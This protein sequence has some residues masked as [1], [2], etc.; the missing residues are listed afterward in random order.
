MQI[1]KYV[2]HWIMSLGMLSKIVF[3]C[4]IA[5]T[6]ATVSTGF[7]VYY[8]SARVI[9]R[10]IYAHTS[11][12]MEQSVNYLN[13]RLKGILVQVHLLQLS[14]NFNETLRMLRWEQDIDYSVGLSRIEPFLSQITA[15]ERILHSIYVYTPKAVFYNLGAPPFDQVFPVVL[16]ELMGTSRPSFIHWGFQ[17]PYVSPLPIISIALQ[18]MTLG[19]TEPRDLYI[20]INLKQEYLQDY[21]NGIIGEAQGEVY[22][23]DEQHR[24][25]VGAN[26]G[27]LSS[28]LDDQDF[29]TKL[30]DAG[31]GGYFK[32][33][34]TDNLLVNTHEFPINGWKMVSIQHESVIFNDLDAIKGM[35]LLIAIILIVLVS[36]LSGLVAQTITKPLHRLQIMMNETLYTNFRARFSP[37]YDDEIGQL[38]HSFDMMSAQVEKLLSQVELEQSLVKQEQ[39][40]KRKAELRALQAQINPHFLYNA[41]DSIYWRAMIQGDSS[42]SEIAVSLSNVFRLG[43]NKGKESTTIGRELEHVTNYMRTQEIVYSGKFQFIVNAEPEL[44]Q[45]E[46]VKIILQPLAENS[47]IHGFQQMEDGGRIS[48]NCYKKENWVCIEVMDNGCGFDKDYLNKMADPTA[49]LEGYALQNIIERLKLYYGETHDFK[50]ESEPYQETKVTIHVPLRST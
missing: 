9:E 3:L 34:Y 47:I 10:N 25:L 43:L 36:I 40:Q 5:V 15:R 46:I 26:N 39:S 2:K 44:M 13:E 50:I 42:I 23:I 41:L 16:P 8:Q 37:K 4:F 12:T 11:E 32:Y 20:I 6:L 14:E 30:T 45:F 29:I 27:M 35:I 31:I 17:Q 22:I 49:T 33:T 7:V 1:I 28:L 18:A 38:A 24:L 19:H 48:I 21:L